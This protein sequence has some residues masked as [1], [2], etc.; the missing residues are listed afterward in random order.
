MKKNKR[1]VVALS[2]GVDSS[3]SA[4]LLKKEGYDIIALF[5]RN[6]HDNSL[7]LKNECP[8]V[9]DSNYAL[10]VCNQ[11]QIPFQVIDLSK[12]YKERIV[13]Y[14]IREYE[15]GNTP[16]P[17]ILCN[18]EIKFDVFLKYAMKLNADFIATGH[19]CRKKNSNNL[20]SLHTGKDPLKD[21][22]YF[23]CQITQSQLEKIIFPIGDLTKKQVREIA[24][25]HHLITAQKKDSQG[26][27]F[28]GKIKL[29][30]FLEN[31][32]KNKKGYIIEI[33]KDSDVYNRELSLGEEYQYTPLMGE[34][35]GQHNGAHCFTAGQRKGLDIGGKNEPLF[36]ISTDIKKNIIYVGMGAS[37]PGLFRMDLEIKTASINWLND[38]Q[39]IKINEER[40]YLVRI[41]HRQTF[42][43]ARLIM[44]KTQLYISFSQKQR[45]IAKGQFAAWYKEDQLIGSGEIM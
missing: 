2:G 41:R 14:M 29:P 35:I 13:D 45:G 39:K 10:E 21:Q 4:L 15:K 44:K 24:K 3:V 18:R 11:L 23:L 42:Q 40:P 9:E 12:E 5:M 43:K 34:K 20:Y 7:T 6:W 37:H 25:K 1:I 22:S 8:W 17:D 32:I 26:L 33:S 27:C 28:V 16:N 31:Q 38:N 19:Y 36:V 30:I